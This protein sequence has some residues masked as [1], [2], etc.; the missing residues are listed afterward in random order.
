M[1]EDPGKRELRLPRFPREEEF[2][3]VESK[4]GSALIGFSVDREGRDNAELFRSELVGE[5]SE[6]VADKALEVRLF[7]LVRPERLLKSRPEPVKVLFS[8]EYRDRREGELVF[9]DCICL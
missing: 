1:A 5:S 2:V 3:N 9:A 7:K 6:L 4:L 8:G